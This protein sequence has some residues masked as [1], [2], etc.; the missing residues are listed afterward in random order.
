MPFDALAVPA[1]RFGILGPL[2]VLAGEHHVK[3]GSA[4]QQIVLAVLLCNANSPVSIDLLTEALWGM[5]PPRTARKNVQVYVSA[6]R[7]LVDTGPTRI[8]YGAGGYVFRAQPA[9]LDSLDFERHARSRHSLRYSRQPADNARALAAGLGLWRGPVLDGLRDVPLID[10]AARRLERQFLDVF[11]DW[12]EAEIAAGGAASVI[13]RITDIAERHPLRERLRTLQMAAL[14]DVGRVSEALAVYD[15][16]RQS[17]AH[18]LGL[19]PTP[20]VSGFYQSL[21]TEQ[22]TARPQAPPVL[23]PWDLPD[24]TGR[25]EHTR[26]LA[27]ALSGRNRVMVVTGSAG[28]GKTALAVHAAHQLGDCFPDGRYFVRLRREDGTPRS[29]QEVTSWLAQ[30]NQVRPEIPVTDAGG[31]GLA[32]LAGQPPGA[33]HTRRCPQRA[34]GPPV[35]ARGRGERGDHHRQAQARRARIRVPAA[36]SAVRNRR[37][38]GVPRPEDRS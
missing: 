23:L 6:L 36:R 28:A 20:A 31:E 5:T 25:A 4:K 14:R 32:A 16:L 15:E 24:F 18:E 8:S 38:A 33:G 12:A 9:E 10:A 2:Q 37:C 1:P 19:S 13:E 30:A 22:E 34:G 21:V 27:D 7:D 11:E 35:P 26:Q 17:L 3:L 29:A